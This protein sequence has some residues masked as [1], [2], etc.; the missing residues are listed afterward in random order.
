[1]EGAQPGDDLEKMVELYL[2]AVFPFQK[3]D[4]KRAIEKMK[5]MLDRWVNSVDSITVEPL[6]NPV[7]EAK[8]ARR[9]AKGRQQLASQDLALT[10]FKRRKLA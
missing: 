10:R 1:M 9:I 7:S 6:P 2:N 8:I 3:A 5:Q 4:A